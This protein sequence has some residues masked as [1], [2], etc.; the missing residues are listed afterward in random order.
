MSESYEGPR[1]LP[2]LL[3]AMYLMGCNASTQPPLIEREEY[4]LSR[5]RRMQ[6][7]SLSDPSVPLL[8]WMQASSLVA[9]YLLRRG[10]L[11]EARQEVC[12]SSWSFLVHN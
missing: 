3:N 5:T 2:G 11:L 10:R 7:K 9:T 6:A 4:Y 8:Q 1:P 12:R